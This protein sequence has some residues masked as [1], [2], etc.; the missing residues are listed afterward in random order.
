MAD[1]TF[2]VAVRQASQQDGIDNT[3][4]RSA[5]ADSQRQR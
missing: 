2:G 4:D 3:E 1:D 5:R